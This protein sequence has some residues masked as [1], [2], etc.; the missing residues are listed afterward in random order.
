VIE[1]QG[2]CRLCP[3]ACGADRR[4][5]PA[6]FC[7][8]GAGIRAAWA[9]LHFGEEPP[10]TGSGG[11]GTIFFS[12]CTLK[13][14]YC[15]NDQLSRRGLG[16]VLSSGE[17]AGLMLALEREGAENVNLVTGSQFAPAIAEAAAQA[18]RQGLSIPLLWN[19]SG[20]ESLSTLEL[21]APWIDVYLPDCKTLDPGLSRRFMGAP[22]YPQAAREALPAMAEARPLRFEGERLRQGVIVRHLVLPGFLESTRE[23]LAWFRERLYGR[24]LLSVMLQYTPNRRAAGSEAG[25]GPRAQVG[26]PA[27]SGPRAG[28][29]ERGRPPARRVNREEFL[30]VQGLLEELSIEQGFIQE[31]EPDSDWLPDF[32]RRNPFPRGQARPLWHYADAALP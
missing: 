1:W 27:A 11:S 13:C 24:A 4:S 6:G 22:D 18:R 2:C 25:S 15:Q 7:R 9:G 5:R 23:V 19:S 32:T 16:R 12:G 17:L 28:G 20:Y 29:G 10:L 8:Q 31:P 21:L 3:R 14:R 30:Q 26:A